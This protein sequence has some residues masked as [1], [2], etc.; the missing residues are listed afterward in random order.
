M[1]SSK[2]RWIAG[3]IGAAIIAVGG[4]AIGFRDLLFPKGLLFPLLIAAAGL[5]IALIFATRN[6]PLPSKRV[7]RT[8]ASV[9]AL[10]LVVSV[11][12]LWWAPAGYFDGSSPTATGCDKTGRSVNEWP[13]LQSGTEA[14]IATA[15][16]MHSTECGT[17]W[18]R[19]ETSVPNATTSNAV[20]RATSFPLLAAA[21]A[22]EVDP[23]TNKGT[24]SMQVY[25]PGCVEIDVIVSVDDKEEGKVSEGC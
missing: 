10:L 11:G 7:T 2:R 22:P 24:Y 5:L 12:A 14:V 4:I 17:S 19:T 15:F 23:P 9:W 13:I 16:L 25:A 3:G 6:S 1:N 21:P 18:V 8:G 20:S